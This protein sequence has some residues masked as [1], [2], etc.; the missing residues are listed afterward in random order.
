VKLK[1]PPSFVE[2][3]RIAVSVRRT[4]TRRVRDRTVFFRWC[5]V[6]PLASLP[7]Q[8]PADLL[9]LPQIIESRDDF[10]GSPPFAAPLQPKTPNGPRLSPGANGSVRMSRLTLIDLAGSEQATSQSE[11]RSEGAFINKR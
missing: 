7:L 1:S 8:A 11:R 3:K 2:G 5:A 10:A 4:S 9:P 6:S